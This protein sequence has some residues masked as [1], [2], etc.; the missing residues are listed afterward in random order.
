MAGIITMDEIMTELLQTDWT[1]VG[2][3]PKTWGKKRKIDTAVWELTCP[4]SGIKMDLWATDILDTA[5][6]FIYD[7]DNRKTDIVFALPDEEDDLFTVPKEKAI[8]WL[9]KTKN[10]E[11]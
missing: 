9:K 4:N 6:V 2:V 10:Y 5:R 8:K 7:G 3:Y 1:R 11:D